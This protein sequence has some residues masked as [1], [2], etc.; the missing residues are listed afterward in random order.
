[1]TFRKTH[2]VAFEF[3]VLNLGTGVCTMCDMCY[4]SGDSVCC[5]VGGEMAVCSEGGGNTIEEKDVGE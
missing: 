5:V 3:P 1:M 2:F 4:F